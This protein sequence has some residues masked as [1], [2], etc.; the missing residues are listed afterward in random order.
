[1]LC[2]FTNHQSPVT[3]VPNLAQFHPQVVHF[4]V[5]LMLLGVAFRLVSL[6]GKLK[7]TD[8]A[9]AVL[10]IVGAIAAYVAHKSGIDAHGP[11][12]RIPG[13]RAMVQAHEADGILTYRIFVSIA[14]IELAALGLAW[15]ANLAKFARYAQAAS[16]VVGIWGC[17]QV[18]ET[19]E[20]G[21]ELVY[22]Y[23]GG[24]GLRS[25]KPEDVE[26]LLLAGLYNQSRNDRREGRLADA[27]S[28][29]SEM[30]K[31]FGADTNVQFLNVESLLLDSKNPTVALIAVNT[32]SVAPNDARFAPRKANLRADI[33]LAMGK[34]DSARAAISEAAAA[35]PQN[36]RLKARLDSLK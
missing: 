1:L 7:F 23:A 3:V 34:R 8:H 2:P 26:R 12:E 32:I 35:F 11:V 22:N 16:A 20:H 29:N 31:R 4:V 24:P 9:A 33:F 13:A 14:I 27:A 19:A 25:G 18:Y 36:L 17:V 6:S 30:V 28:L 21:G 15:R 5:V 10:L